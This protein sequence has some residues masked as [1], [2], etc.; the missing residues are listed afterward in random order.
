MTSKEDPYHIR[1]QIELICKMKSFLKFIELF[2][3]FC[4]NLKLKILSKNMLVMT[5]SKPKKKF[6]AS[7][8][9]REFCPGTIPSLSITI[10]N[11][12]ELHA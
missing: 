6:I 8:L 9:S 7:K 11:K 12:F 4:N 1:S 10:L 3:Y 2:Q 5:F